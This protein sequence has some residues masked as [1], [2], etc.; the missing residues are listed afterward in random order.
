MSQS[1]PQQTAAHP[2]PTPAVARRTAQVL[3]AG[4][5]A[6]PL[7]F[8]VWALQA[9]TRDGFEPGRHPLSLLSLGGP[10]WSQI[11]NFVVTGALFASCAVGMRRALQP[12]P[13]HTWAPRL[14]G[15][16]GAGLITSGVFLTDAG[17]GFPAG[18]P[19]GAPEMSWHG[20]LHE[21]GYVVAMLSWAA[22]CFVLRRR[23]ATLAQRRWAR[24]CV[25]TIVAVLVLS[26][27]PDGDSFTIRITIA[28]AVQFGFL[29][30]VAIHLQKR[31]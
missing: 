29:A 13:G 4:V 14:V 31:A 7:F 8:T 18:A 19:A 3:G 30:A 1:S 21:L 10:G 2:T 6:G 17:A 16:F 26:A 23:F 24:A 12:G 9:F 27:W 15:A 20:A 5:L 25:A 28:T 11:A 22:A